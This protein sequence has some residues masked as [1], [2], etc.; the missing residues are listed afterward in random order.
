MRI[1]QLID[2]LEMGG[3]ER[4]A[5]NI[6]NAF[7]EVG[8]ES[9]L[10]VSRKEGPLSKF[11]L[12]GVTL[13]SLQK[14]STFDLKAFKKLMGLVKEI[15]PDILHAHST[16]IY[17]AVGIRMFFPKVKLIWHDHLGVNEE[18]IR[19]NPRKEL[20]IFS[21]FIHGIITVNSEIRD[22][23]I[24][25]LGFSPNKIKYI[26][27]F[28]FLNFKKKK[29]LNPI[30]NILHVANFRKEKGHL[31]LLKAVEILQAQHFDFHLKLIGQVMD[32]QIFQ[33]VNKLINTNG[34]NNQ[35]SVLGPIEDVGEV[36]LSGDVGLVCSDREGLPVALL[37]YGLAGLK[38]IST[39]VGICA[40]VLGQGQYGYIVPANSPSHLAE[41]IVYV[42][43]QHEEAEEK[44]IAFQRHVKEMYGSEQFLTEYFEFLQALGLSNQTLKTN[45][46]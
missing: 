24:K 41:T 20:K 2:T 42:S 32:E 7:S 17:W 29:K 38:V 12:P 14:R 37:E 23:W 46:H 40:E 19:D 22:W 15:K 10:A 27:N 4:M 33:E 44:A 28:P 5:V 26:K 8:I 9:F 31:N 18:V 13:H 16:S 35:V 45:L 3:A 39:D 21:K 34:W 25:E 1:L 6:A 30:P 36:L 11:L 43:T